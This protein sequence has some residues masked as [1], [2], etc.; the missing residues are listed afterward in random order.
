MYLQFQLMCMLWEVASRLA[1]SLVQ[2]VAL[3][4]EAVLFAKCTISEPSLT[5]IKA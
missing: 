4:S 3:G 2:P 1:W 5:Q